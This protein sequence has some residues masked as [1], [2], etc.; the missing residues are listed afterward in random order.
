VPQGLYGF[1]SV[2]EAGEAEEEAGPRGLSAVGDTRGNAPKDRGKADSVERVEREERRGGESLAVTEGTVRARGRVP[3][4]GTLRPSVLSRDVPDAS[5]GEE[6]GEEEEVG[7]DDEEEEEEDEEGGL[8][9]LL[10][11]V[12]VRACGC[13]SRRGCGRWVGGGP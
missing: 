2:E 6:E 4:G 3:L 10:L 11:G 7:D 13:C 12:A 5:M 1:V 8:L 9:L